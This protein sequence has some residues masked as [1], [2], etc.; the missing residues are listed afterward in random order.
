MAD[1]D[2][3]LARHFGPLHDK[4]AQRLSDAGHIVWW[5]RGWW[6]DP[7]KCPHCKESKKRGFLEVLKRARDRRDREGH[8]WD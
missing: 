2:L 6:H 3:P 4:M 1:D 7:A 8:P 5:D